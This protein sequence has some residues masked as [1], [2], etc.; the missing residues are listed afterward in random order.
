ML[1]WRLVIFALLASLAGCEPSYPH[2]ARY[3]LNALRWKGTHNSYHLATRGAPLAYDYSHAPLATQLADQDVRQFE[4]DVYYD[5]DAA[6]FLVMHLPLFDERSTCAT[7]A[8]CL[9]EIA[10]WGE[11]H[12]WHAPII[13][14]IE[15]K[16]EAKD[17]PLDDYFATL[18][19]TVTQ[20]LGAHRLITPAAVQGAAANVA[21]A[22]RT[23]GWPTLA[24]TRGKFLVF[25]LADSSYVDTY[26]KNELRDRPLFVTSGPGVS[27]AAI[28]SVD[29]PSD[30]AAIEAALAANMLVRTR[31]DDP[32]SPEERGERGEAALASGAHIVATDYPA[33]RDGY[34]LPWPE[35]A[36]LACHPSLAPET[37]RP[38][39]L[40]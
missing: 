10:A 13:I 27:F 21:E 19:A 18:D 26:A 7:L 23:R 30:S 11:A 28:Q 38:D 5:R 2:D 16:N 20:S 25:M 9:A 34:A 1:H 24:E 15:P 40:E 29:L 33:T 4:L 39:D 35:H 22:L 14:M 3:P 6:R 31:A 32:E 17:V 36:I 12:P 37:C 8:V